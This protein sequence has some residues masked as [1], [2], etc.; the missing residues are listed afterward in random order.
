[1]AAV[2]TGLA[3]G[4]LWGIGTIYGITS[5][6]TVQQVSIFMFTFIIGGAINQYLV[7]YLSDKYDRRTI[8]VIVSL[9]AGLLA[10]LAVILGNNFFFLISITFIFGGLTVPLYPLA[11]AHTND[12]LS[13]KE[14]VAASSGLQLAG[15][16]GLTLGPILAG[17]AI[18]S[19]G[20]NG[21]WIYLFLIH[22]SLGLFG[23]YR[24]S[25]RTAV[26]L[27]EQGTT[28][29]MSSRAS[30]VSMELY[31]DAEDSKLD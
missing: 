11:I 1:V 22:S 13:K 14:M 7:G 27:D 9:L 25:V 24:M 10:A 20:A 3:H 23:L 12:F 26:P 4:A 28:V 19:I 29:L 17:L 5:G 6:L 8:I 16:I 30:P 2:L 21:F 15:G 18:D 31:S